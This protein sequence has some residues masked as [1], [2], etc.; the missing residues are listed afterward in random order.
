MHSDLMPKKA[1]KKWKRALRQGGK[2]EVRS[3]IEQWR[4][5]R[6]SRRKPRKSS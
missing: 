3:E 1:W 6:A 2:D 5:D 4:D